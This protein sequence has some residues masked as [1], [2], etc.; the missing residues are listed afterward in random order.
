[1]YKITYLLSDFQGWK[2]RYQ[3]TST[4]FVCAFNLSARVK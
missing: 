1:M 3:V 2:R 4:W